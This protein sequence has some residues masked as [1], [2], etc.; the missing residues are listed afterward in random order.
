MKPAM[1]NLLFLFFVYYCCANAIAQIPPPNVRIY[2]SS[3]TQ[4]EPTVAVDPENPDRLFASAVTINTA[5][6]FTS[7][8]VYVTT[9]GG[10]HWN[11]SDTCKGQLLANHGGDPGVMI[12]GNGRLV[13]TH[14]GRFFPGVY[15]HYSTDFGQTWSNAYTIS[16]DQPEDKGSSAMDDHPSSPYYGRMYTA[17]VRLVVPYP[18]SF[19]SSTDAGTSWAPVS[20][21]NPGPP[22]RCS[23]GAIA[24]GID[25]KVYVCWSGVTSAAPFTEDFAGFAFSTDG[26]GT[27]T[28]TQNA[29]DMNGINGT[30]PS[31]SNIRVNGLPD[32]AVD[33]SQGLRQGWLYIVTTE[34]NL[35]PA[36]SDPDI[37]LHRSTDGGLSWSQG[38]RV[39]QDS[40][41][42]GKT[43]YFPAIEI[44]DNGGINIVYYDDRL[45]TADSAY[46]MLSRSV[47]GGTTWSEHLVSDHRFKPKPIIG[48]SS[49]YQGDHIA[50]A[51]AGTRLYPFWMDDYSG[52]YQVWSCSIDL[53]ALPVEEKDVAIPERSE[54][55][56]NFPNPFNPSTTIQYK[57]ARSGFVTLRVLDV[58]GR[59]VETLVS[60]VQSA[61][62]HRVVFDSRGKELASGVYLCQLFSQDYSAVMPML[63]VR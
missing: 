31:K 53:T 18:V 25:G 44:D 4:T 12:H 42:N 33:D 20:V 52:L 26:G 45:T 62:H 23:G 39:N 32:I 46:V 38:I 50:L 14:I 59:E 54:L 43:Q 2:P 60:E 36:G 17:W 37:I 19:S 48:G 16:S 8:G 51:S 5:T 49:N 47:D 9:D 29:F 22:A 28:V 11:G 61:G 30:L 10:I 27:W 7:E 58:I 24:T 40:L 21:V 55:L 41:N 34:R 15:S 1:K 13:L 56:Q 63:L 57:L 3:V 6:T 35:A